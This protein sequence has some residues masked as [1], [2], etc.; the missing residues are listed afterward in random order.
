[1]KEVIENDTIGFLAADPLQNDDRPMPYFIIGD[2]AFPP[3]STWLTKNSP[4]VTCWTQNEYTT[5]GYP[6]GGGGASSGE[7]FRHFEHHIWMPSHH[8]A[9]DTKSGGIHWLGLSLSS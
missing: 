7:C 2:Y 9:T 4:D 6:G 8:H 3:L 1:M 5:T